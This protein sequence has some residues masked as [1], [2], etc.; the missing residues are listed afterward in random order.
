MKEK[1]LVLVVLLV[2][3]SITI[4]SSGCKG[5]K[6]NKFTYKGE[7]NNWSS[8]FYV[9]KKINYIR[10][11]QGMAGKGILTL[12]YKGDLAE[13]SSVKFLEYTY[14]TLEGGATKTSRSPEPGN[15][16]G[17]RNFLQETMGIDK[18]KPYD[19]ET[20]LRVTIKWDG[21]NG[22]TETILLKHQ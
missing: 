19:I 7:S 11:E 20:I 6:N 17:D 12:T 18:T 3:V 22:G 16:F 9:D 5:V 15:P 2:I 21:D 10:T 4:L 8:S 1:R 13:L 14:E